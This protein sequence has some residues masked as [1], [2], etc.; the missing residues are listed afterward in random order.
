MHIARRGPVWATW[1]GMKTF[2]KAFIRANSWLS[3]ILAKFHFLSRM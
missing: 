1:A 3:E 2:W